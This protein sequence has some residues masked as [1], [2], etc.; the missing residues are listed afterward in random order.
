VEDRDDLYEH[1]KVHIRAAVLHPD[2]GK[3][4][5]VSAVDHSSMKGVI[6]RLAGNFVYVEVLRGVSQKVLLR[7]TCPTGVRHD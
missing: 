5:V 3:P 1:G 7:R 2:P 4:K 6:L